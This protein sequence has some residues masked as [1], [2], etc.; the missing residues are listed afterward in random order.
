MVSRSA[1]KYARFRVC[2]NCPFMAN[3]RLWNWP[4]CI[5]GVP[6]RELNDD[7]FDG[8]E[9]DCPEGNWTNLDVKAKVPADLMARLEAEAALFADRNAICE[10]CEGLLPGAIVCPLSACG[11]KCRMARLKRPNMACPNTPPAWGPVEA[12]QS[13]P[14]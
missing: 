1:L 3:S 2:D 10:M 11:P 7:A 13:A 4:K 9:T 12:P 8:P 6:T 14:S 5:A